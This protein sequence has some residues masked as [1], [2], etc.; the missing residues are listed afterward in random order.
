YKLYDEK[1]VR[2]DFDIDYHFV[3]PR[4]GLN[5]NLTDRWNVYGNIAYTSREPRLNNLYDATFS[6]TGEVPQFQ[7]TSAGYSFDEPLVNPEKLLDFELGAGYSSP[8]Y[9]LSA[10]LYWMS[11]RD[12]IVTSGQLDLFGQPITGNADRTRHVGL[13]LSGTALLAEGLTLQANA[14]LSK[15]TITRHTT[16][17][18]TF[19]ADAPVIIPVVLDGNTIG[20]FPDVLANA[21]LTYDRGGWFASLSLRHVGEQFTDNFENPN[22]NVDAYTVFNF[23]VGIRLNDIGEFNGLEVRLQVNN[24]FDALYAAHGVGDEF[25]PAAERNVFASLKVEL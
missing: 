5:I 7:R 12:E 18:V 20:G 14:T 16:Y 11:F 3:N 2:T 1:F 15:N 13:E 19:P 24:L 10:N 9:R 21:R 17:A 4:V 6:W 8:V 23:I 25:F 22:R